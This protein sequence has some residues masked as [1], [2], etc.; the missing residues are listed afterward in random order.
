MCNAFKDGF[1]RG[2]IQVASPEL[3]Q[4]MKTVVNDGGSIEAPGR[5]KDDRVIASSLATILWVDTMRRKLAQGGHTYERDSKVEAVNGNA[6]M[7]VEQ[8]QITNYLRK[9]GVAAA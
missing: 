5:L 6:A 8:R 4:E 2:Y 7:S 9:I 3:L 1:E